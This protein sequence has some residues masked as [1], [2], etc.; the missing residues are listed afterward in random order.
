MTFLQRLSSP[1]KV[2][3]GRSYRFFSSHRLNSPFFSPEENARIYGKCN[4]PRGHGHTYVLQ[5]MI[6]GIP[7]PKTGMICDLKELDGIV[8]GVLSRYHY[9]TL[10]ELPEY[11]ELPS[12]G[13]RICR[14]ILLELKRLLSRKTFSLHSVELSETRNNFFRAQQEEQAS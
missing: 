3:L 6:E 14:N 9:Q 5:I 4:H 12:T 11:R 7:D 10:E 2:R 1:L 8:W 13:E